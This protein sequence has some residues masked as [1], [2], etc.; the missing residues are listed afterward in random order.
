MCVCVKDIMTCELWASENR[1]K[2]SHE[3]FQAIWKSLHKYTDET[4]A[5]LQ[6]I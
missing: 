2:S 5:N 4:H 1:E 3:L 6:Q